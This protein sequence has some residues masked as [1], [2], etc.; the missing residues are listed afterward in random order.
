M[1]D[2]S[3][4]AVTY[5]P[6]ID[7]L[8]A[9]AVVAVIGFHAGIRVFAGGYVGVD[10][11]FVIS[12]FLITSIICKSLDRGAFS[13]LDFYAR[14][15]KR[16]FPALV[17][18]LLAVSAYGW[19]VLLPGEFERLGKHVMAGAGFVSNLVLWKEAG[20][21]DKSAEAKPL[22]HLW[23]LG[24]E[25]QFYLLWPPLLV[26][27]WR[28]RADVLAVAVAIV[29]ISFAVNVMLITL[30]QSSEAYYL[31]PTR[32]WELLLGSTLGYVS[33]FRKSEIENIW[34]RSVSYI[35]GLEFLATSDIRGTAG[36]LLI[37]ISIVGLNQQMLFPGWW[38]LLPTVGTILVISAGPAA[39]INRRLLSSKPFVF[40][41]LISY[42][43]YLW[44]WPL[45]SYA[46]IIQPGPLAVATAAG[47]VAI[48]F[49]L[50]SLTF[51]AVEKPLRSKSKPWAVPCV[52]ALAVCVCLG[53]VLFAHQVHAR[54]ESSGLGTILNVE[55]ASWDFPGRSLKPF[56]TSL[57]YHFERGD[58]SSRVLFIGDS[59]AQQYYPRIDRLLTEHPDTTRSIAFVTAL[60][61]PPLIRVEQ[62]VHPKCKGMMENAFAVADDLHVDTV[63]IAAGWN[64]YDAF[65]PN[66]P[67]TAFRDL[68]SIL[69]KFRSSGRTVYLVLPVPKG[70]AFAPS[71]IVK[72]RFALSG[73][74]V[75]QR[76]R[77]SEVDPWGRP[78]AAKLRSIALSNGAVP[79]DPVDYICHSEDCPTLAEDGL[80]M[81][82]DGSHL[83]S[84]YVRNQITFLDDIVLKNNTPVSPALARVSEKP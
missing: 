51:W 53:L 9:V 1:S 71:S 63:V 2:V 77:L 67:D 15:A 68:G 10:I 54:S 76:M 18:V 40:I 45:L 55:K 5:R 62:L 42:S 16:I 80:P 56:H 46:H 70:D 19:F 75:V 78:I 7:G 66:G 6:D 23:S 52:S 3:R 69:S 30:W 38:G 37:I 11:F 65:D 64:R 36:L 28:R 25:E 34:K 72:R 33:L 83:R 49:L 39:W 61:C 22:L 41:G 4:A 26:W 84:D 59:H 20:Y 74:S 44:H 12:G 13:F 60:G 31:P 58:D 27:A 82:C 21:F 79:I 43:L 73:F 35:P 17:V 14:R 29:A 57:G 48:A 8:R 81:Y 50:A 24:I 32:F 47:A